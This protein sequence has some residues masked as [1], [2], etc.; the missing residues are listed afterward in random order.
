[1]D[2]SLVSHYCLVPGL[3]LELTGPSS[4]RSRLMGDDRKSVMS[5]YL[6][7]G[8]FGCMLLTGIAINHKGT[9]Y[10]KR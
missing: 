2:R 5:L 1:M 9:H 7:S 4:G 6:W 8:R 3:R 10:D